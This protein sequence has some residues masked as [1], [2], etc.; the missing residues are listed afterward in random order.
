MGPNLLKPQ[1]CGR[2]DRR[3]GP[4]CWAAELGFGESWAFSGKCDLEDK[5]E[6]KSGLKGSCGF[7]LLG[8]TLLPGLG[9]LFLCGLGTS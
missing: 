3:E 1:S 2:G 8:L 4:G 9:P 5:I 7:V 6:A